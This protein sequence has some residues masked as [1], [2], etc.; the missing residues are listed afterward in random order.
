MDEG[1][2]QFFIKEDNNWKIIGIVGVLQF[3]VI[4]YCLE[5]EYGVR[6][7]YELV[8]F[9]KVCWVICDDEKAM[10]EFIQWWKWDFVCDKY[11]QFVYLVEFVWFL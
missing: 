2:V 1:V 8:N 3:E 7:S 6:C 11:G 5:Y 10:K 4:Q 9:Y